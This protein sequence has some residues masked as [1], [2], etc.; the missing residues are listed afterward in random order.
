MR[1]QLAVVAILGMLVSACLADGSS[2][3]SSST[4]PKPDDPT[5]VDDPGCDGYVDSSQP[6]STTWLKQQL[7]AGVC[8]TDV[9]ATD[10]AA[11]THE[12]YA[13]CQPVASTPIECTLTA[14]MQFCESGGDSGHWTLWCKSNQDCP[15]GAGCLWPNGVGDVP[16]DYQPPLG[17][18][19][20]FCETVG[21]DECGRCDMECD[22]NLKVCVPRRPP[23]GAS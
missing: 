3:S 2:S 18:C 15:Q 5:K 8:S 21:S 17:T 20:P 13:V 6:V 22:L 1:L 14:G 19:Q 23:S 16:D 11:T 12:F 10:V 9:P 4:D 7:Q